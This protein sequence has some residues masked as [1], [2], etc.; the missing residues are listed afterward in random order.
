M[1]RNYY[2]L[3]RLIRELND[4]FRGAV[5]TECFSQEKDQIVFTFTAGSGVFSLILSASQSNPYILFR[6]EYHKAR[7]NTVSFFQE[8]FP[9]VLEEVQ[10]AMDDRIIKYCFPSFGIYFFTR[11][12][13]TNIV[14]ITDEGETYTFK[15]TDPG[16]LS[17][18][19][20]EL[21][22]KTYSPFYH[23]PYL[24][25]ISKEG[26]FRQI[27]KKEFPAVSRDM[28]QEVNA[29]SATGG[30]EELA[31]KLNDVIEEIE[32]A[33]IAVFYDKGGNKMNFIPSTF[34]SAKSE[35]DKETFPSYL[36][37]ISSYLIKYFK[38]QR[39]IELRHKAGRYL[40]NQTEKL[41][42]KL[43]QISQK[44]ESESKEEE[45]RQIGNLLLAN[46]RLIRKGMSEIELED[47]YTGENLKIRLDKTLEPGDNCARYFE[48][49]KNEKQSRINLTSLFNELEK[50]YLGLI[51]LKKEFESADKPEIIKGIMDKLNIRENQGGGGQNEKE[52]NFKHYLIEG[53]YHVYVGRDSHN[54]DILTVKF[55]KQNDYWFHARGVPGSHVVLRV[56][57]SKDPIPKPV[58]KKAASIAAYHSKAKTS[59]MAPVAYTFKKY[60]TKKK[61]ME[62]GKVS[63][64]REEV[65]LVPPE[66]PQGCEF[67]DD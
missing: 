19:T 62:P 53:K 33:D 34:L 4:R 45:Y 36:E 41:S 35:S 2:Y 47:F 42:V 59:K 27:I 6:S 54:N 43:H 17:E 24:E 16:F 57:S 63:L 39:V 66:V 60:V 50:R 67:L 13:D 58:I 28:M 37:A 7:K 44:L 49:A 61:G 38:A 12:K 51:E 10:I 32:Q 48:K 64:L 26:D 14:L 9:A 15:K 30:N 3:N 20:G 8:K 29:R 46:L 1:Y 55:A 22:S 56:E 31:E 11:G 23:K 5:L 52:F 40:E 25:S 21:L 18:I 65:L